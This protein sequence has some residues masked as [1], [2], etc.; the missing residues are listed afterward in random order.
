LTGFNE[1][2]TAIALT[3]AAVVAIA[4]FLLAVTLVARGWRLKP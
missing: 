4:G 1:T 3:V 2:S